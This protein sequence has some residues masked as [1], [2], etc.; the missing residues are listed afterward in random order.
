M[1]RFLLLLA[2]V[3]PAIALSV[4][5]QEPRAPGGR[6]QFQFEPRNP[7]SLPRVN[8]IQ[9]PSG[10]RHSFV[11][12]GV[13]GF[14]PAQS[15]TILADSVEYYEDTRL[16]YLIGN[17]E[18]DEPR[19]SLDAQRITYWQNEERVLSEGSVDAT[20]PSG[21]NLKGPKVDY[22]RAVPR[23]RPQARM[24]SD[25]RPT[26]RIIERDSLG[27]ASDP[28][29]VIA[30]TVVMLA[31]SLVYAS[32]RVELTRPDVIALAD[33]ATLDNGRQSARLMRKPVIEGRGERPFKLFGTVIDIFA[34]NRKLEFAIAR[35]EGKA[36]SEDVTL[37]ADTL[38]FRLVDSKLHRAYAWGKSRARAMSPQY[39]IVA[40]SLDVRMPAQKV[41]EVYAVRDA[42]AQSTPDSLRVQTVE[43]DWLRGDTILA[44]FDT[45]ATADTTSRAQIRQLVAL[46]HAR[47]LYQLAPRDTALNRPAINYVIG[48]DISLA[49]QNREVQT[50]TITEQAHGVYLEP[51][52]STVREGEPNR[53]RPPTQPAPATARPP[54]S[55]SP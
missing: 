50:V 28:V 5:A 21:T 27:S 51:I 52:V 36:I 48:R 44:L 12:G 47:S 45:A 10:A 32:G 31:D 24:I 25:G 26:I 4:T 37:T 29:I 16:M 40:D 41:S 3:A 39:D 30:N 17:V 46:G 14:C 38:D 43:K 54:E 53:P 23:T 2:A 20:L 9:Q 34:R 55:R 11:G 35:G 6:C 19:L 22:Y 49:F 1:S 42:F 18:Y 33:S 8:S 7:A 13:R 15:I